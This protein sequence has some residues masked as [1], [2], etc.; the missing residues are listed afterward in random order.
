MIVAARGDNLNQRQHVHR[1]PFFLPRDAR[2]WGF[3]PSTRRRSLTTLADIRRRWGD[4]IRG[5]PRRSQQ[6]YAGRA[7]SRASPAASPRRAKARTRRAPQPDGIDAGFERPSRGAAPA[8]R[9]QR[10]GARRSGV[11]PSWLPRSARWKHRRDAW[12]P[13]PARPRRGSYPG[14]LAIAPIEPHRNL[15]RQNILLFY[16]GFTLVMAQQDRCAKIRSAR[17]YGNA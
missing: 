5:T 16:K 12:R 9:E 6:A 14:G 4:R 3:R 15:L 10:A 11:G 1:S 17:S 13:L 2:G 8:P 7:A